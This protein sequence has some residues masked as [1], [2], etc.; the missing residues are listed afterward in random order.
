M[1]RQTSIFIIGSVLFVVLAPIIFFYRATPKIDIKN[2][3]ISEMT[4]CN[5][6]GLDE[7]YENLAKKLYAEFDYKEIMLALSETENIPSVFSKCHELSHFIGRKAYKTTPNIK[8]LFEHASPACWGGF[9]HGVIEAYFDA[10]PEDAKEKFAREIKDVCGKKEDY[11]VPRLFDECIHGIGHGVMFVTDN[12]LNQSLAWCD[13]LPDEKVRNVC[14][15]GVFM[16]NSSSSTQTG[17]VGESEYLKEKDPLFPCNSLDE[18]YL[19]T[20]YQYQGSYFAFLAKWD[21]E[22]NADLCMLVPEKY[23]PGC[24][25]II[26]SNQVGGSQNVNEMKNTCD[27]MPDAYKNDCVSGV[28]SG[29]TGRYINDPEKTLSFCSLVGY[30]FKQACFNQFGVALSSWSSDKKSLEKFCERKDFAEKVWCLEGL[31]G[32]ESSSLVF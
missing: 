11:S 25:T 21:L 28:V 5:K 22:K 7:C 14:Y 9:Y 23:R 32:G 18:H 4:E 16:E 15:G 2:L 26:G 1:Q 12:N 30:S 27:K 6:T 29:L 3:V 31:S 17:S 19:K 24:F 13:E 20:C 8:S 10:N